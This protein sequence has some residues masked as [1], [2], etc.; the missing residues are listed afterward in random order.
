MSPMKTLRQCAVTG[1]A[2]LTLAWPGPASGAADYVRDG[3][4]VEFGGVVAHGFVPAL[5]D[6]GKD[7]RDRIADLARHI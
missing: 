3:G 7:G 5:A 2:A 4:P 1:L 6:V